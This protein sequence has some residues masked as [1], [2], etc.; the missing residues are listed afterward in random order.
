MDHIFFASNAKKGQRKSLPFKK[1]GVSSMGIQ[2]TILHKSMDIIYNYPGK[3]HPWC[4]TTEQC[5]LEDRAH[6]TLAL[7]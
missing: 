4:C 1:G 2:A 5:D 3:W 7:S 6:L